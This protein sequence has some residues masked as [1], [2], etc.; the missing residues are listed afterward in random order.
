MKGQ[1]NETNC[2][3]H[4]G[5]G[6]SLGM[7]NNAKDANLPGRI[8]GRGDR[9]L[10]AT[11]AAAPSSAASDADLPGWLGDPSG[12]GLPSSSTAAAAAGA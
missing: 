3:Y 1:G 2:A 11:S 5:H 9:A 8:D 12:Y 10:P 6:R 4:R 7:R